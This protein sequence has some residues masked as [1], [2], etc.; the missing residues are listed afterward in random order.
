MHKTSTESKFWSRV[1]KTD[2]CWLWT[3]VKVKGYGQVRAPHG[4]RLLAHRYSA[5]LHFGM[6]DRRLLVLH[7]C[8]TPACVRPDHL[9]LGTPADN[10]RD[11]DARGRNANANKTHCKWGHPYTDENTGR[12]AAGRYCRMCKGLS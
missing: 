5:M 2:D 12:Q 7:H 8:D 9:Y 10:M 4:R 3:G 6:F 1:E 11:R